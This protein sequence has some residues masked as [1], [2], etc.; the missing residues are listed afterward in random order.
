MGY[1]YRWSS[2]GSTRTEFRCCFIPGVP[3]PRL[4]P[5]GAEPYE[6]NIGTAQV[7]LVGPG[8]I[9][10]VLGRPPVSW[11]ALDTIPI[12]RVNEVVLHRVPPG[13]VWP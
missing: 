3:F 2:I 6:S 9:P 13:A 7:S 5:F 12:N 4:S 8:E 1:A 10:D 11:T